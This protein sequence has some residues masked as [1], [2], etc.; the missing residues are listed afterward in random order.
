[1]TFSRTSSE[2]GAVFTQKPSKS[3]WR[4]CLFMA[5]LDI[6]DISDI[7]DLSSLF[8]RIVFYTTQLVTITFEAGN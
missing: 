1:M 8:L 7:S 2:F 6:S 5:K 3:S 4:H